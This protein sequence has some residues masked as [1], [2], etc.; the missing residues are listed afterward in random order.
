M[1]LNLIDKLMTEAVETGATYVEFVVSVQNISF[2]SDGGIRKSTRNYRRTAAEIHADERVLKRISDRNL[3][4]SKQLNKITVT[5]MDGRSAV[6]NRCDNGKYCTVTARRVSEKKEK[7]FS[8]V[9]FFADDLQDTGIAFLLKTLN[10]GKTQIVSCTGEILKG[11]ISTDLST[12]LQFVLSGRFYSQNGLPDSNFDKE[13][14]QTIDSLASVMQGA[15]KEMLHLRLLSM[16][17]FAVL[18]NTSDEDSDLTNA[19]IQ[20]LKTVCRTYP[21]F[22]N[23]N[24]HY[25]S[26]LKIADGTDDVTKLFPQVLA[27]SVLN[28][29]MWLEP[30]KRGGREECFLM[31]MG[32]PYFDRERFLKEL[33]TES[34]FDDCRDILAAQNDK[35]I[36]S[37]Y[38]FC[39]EPI[40]ENSVKRQII[41]GFR[42]ICSI[43]DSRAG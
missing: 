39:T 16:S 5:L 19:L 22:K 36:R 34:H 10:N 15:I 32:I 33:F 12:D 40:A 8:Y 20:S 30:Y 41:S 35:W 26:S 11:V 4:F 14:Q 18:P 9:R 24:G 27:E 23:R 17:L 7:R 6:F 21:V 28:G 37:F 2:T 29:R 1:G 25:L 38:I 31:D 43:R 42:N 3:L 13:N